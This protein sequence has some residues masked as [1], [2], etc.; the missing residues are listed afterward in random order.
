MD[1]ILHFGQQS[2]LRRDVKRVQVDIEAWELGNN[3]LVEVPVW[4]DVGETMRVLAACLVGRAISYP[5]PA[6]VADTQ[7][8]DA[9]KRLNC[10]GND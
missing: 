7:S 1:W 9:G 6:V 2:K 4:A 8:K 3:G 5:F 10:R